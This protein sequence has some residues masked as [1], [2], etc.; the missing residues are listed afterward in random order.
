[1]KCLTKEEIQCLIDN[2]VSDKEKNIYLNHINQCNDCKVLYNQSLQDKELLHDFFSTI[3]SDNFDDSI[4]EFVLPKKKNNYFVL[5]IAAVIFFLI[6]ISVLFLLNSKENISTQ[7]V[8]EINKEY[9][10]LTTN[11]D[12]NKMWQKK[13]MLVEIK[14]ENDNVIET[15]LTNN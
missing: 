13:Q 15:Y 6:G 3:K 8:A 5:K 14:D 7:S 12:Q 10:D 1:M 9:V 2:E 4:P 11:M